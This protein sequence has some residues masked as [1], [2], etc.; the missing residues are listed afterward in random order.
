ML[1]IYFS[2]VVGDN[3]M[4]WQ[5]V[6]ALTVTIAN[7]YQLSIFTTEDDKKMSLDIAGHFVLKIDI[8]NN[9]EMVL[10]IDIY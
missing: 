9:W 10:I 7:C 6:T 8:G 1:E 2:S 5:V 3:C 4:Y